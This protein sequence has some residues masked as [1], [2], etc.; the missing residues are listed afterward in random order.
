MEHTGQRIRYWRR[1]RGGISQKMLADR[2]GVSQGYISLIESGQRALDRRAT[3][4]A[5]AQALNVTVSQLLGQPGDP[6]DPAK[7]A[8]TAVVPDIRSACLE[9]SVGER[10]KPDR[11]RDAVREAVRRSSILRNAADYAGL[12]PGMADLLRDA[13]YY[14]GPEFVEATFNARFLVKGVGYPDLAATVAGIGMD[15]A[16]DLD[17]PQWI[18]LAEISRLNAMPPEN[19]G[20]TSR[21]ATRTASEIQPML[22][23]IDVRQAYGNLLC[24]GALASAVSGDA[25]GASGFLSEAFS[26]AGSLG[27]SED[28]GFGLLW[29]GPTSTA[30]WQVSVA[31]ELGDSDEA[32]SIARGIDPRPVQA[33][34][35][36]VYYWTDY[37]HALTATGD[38]AGAVQAFSEA[39]MVDPQRVR[40]DPMVLDSV[41]ALIRRAR[42]RAVEG[43]I[44]SLAHSLGLDHLT[45]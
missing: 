30:I 36:V 22:G 18:G 17:S 7:A 1:R 24:R 19:A 13:F 28:G 15:V 4:V 2:S 31:A 35:R 38:D 16:L 11:P 20:L 9:M 32:V 33:P 5:I 42:R 44:Q 3:Q 10:R 25:S 12:A 39:E 8:A 41:S 23:D 45:V 21:L 37:G 43:R 27:D 34:N 40:M 14:K 29:F 26:E 6:T